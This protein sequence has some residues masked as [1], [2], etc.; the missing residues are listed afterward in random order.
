MKIFPL[1]FKVTFKFEVCAGH[2]VLGRLEVG[3]ASVPGEAGDGRGFSSWAPFDLELPLQ[4]PC[5]GSALFSHWL[6]MYPKGHFY[7]PL[8]VC[9]GPFCLKISHTCFLGPANSYSILSSFPTGYSPANRI[10]E[11][12]QAVA[13]WPRLYSGKWQSPGPTPDLCG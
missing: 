7:R 1:L 13:F 12:L 6:T 11:G 10:S 9:L 3:G 8:C 5:A 4:C 2:T